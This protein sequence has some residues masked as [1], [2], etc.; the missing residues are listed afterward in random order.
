MNR[1]VTDGR[2]AAGC[3]QYMILER[4]PSPSPTNLAGHSMDR[5]KSHTYNILFPI[6]GML[7]YTGHKRQSLQGVRNWFLPEREL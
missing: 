5:F 7:L 4:R 3:A 2:D 6:S 1:W